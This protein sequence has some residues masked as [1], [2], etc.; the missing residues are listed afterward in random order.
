[1]ISRS[2]R[3]HSDALMAARHRTD[4]SNCVFDIWR[5]DPVQRPYWS[6]SRNPWRTDEKVA[7]CKPLRARAGAA[8]VGGTLS[9]AGRGRIMRRSFF[10][11]LILAVIAA[12]GAG[13][14]TATAA[15]NAGRDP[16]PLDVYTA[17]V[18]AGQLSELAQQGIDV[19]E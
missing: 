8:R 1:M 3:A 9:P 5:H 10:V 6:W 16:D 7:G 17:T 18:E 2:D 19:S 13:L 14:T 12:L 15:P 4:Q 11:I